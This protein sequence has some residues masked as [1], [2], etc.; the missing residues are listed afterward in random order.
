[1]GRIAV[2][3][4]EFLRRPTEAAIRRLRPEMETMMLS[5]NSFAHLPGLYDRCA[6]EVDGFLASGQ[7]TRAAIESQNHALNRPII[8]FQPDT[9]EIYR[10][11]LAYLLEYP[12]QDLGRVILD[13]LLPLEGDHS[14]KR[15]VGETEMT[16]LTDQVGAWL[17]TLNSGE[18]ERIEENTLR[19]LICLWEEGCFDVV[20]CLFSSIAPALE[21]R[22]IPVRCPC[23][24]DGHL[25]DLLRQL[26]LRVQLTELR[27]SQPAAASAAPRG[28][29]AATP[30]NRRALR[31]YLEEFLQE[32]VLDGMLRE[33]ADGVSIFTTVQEVHLLTGGGR[34]DG[35]GASLAQCLDFPTAVGYGVGGSLHLAVRNARAARRESELTGQ[36][37]LRNE[38]GD[39]IGPLD[40]AGP[41]VVKILGGRDVSEIARRCGLS[42]HTI[43]KVAAAM[44]LSGSRHITAQDLAGRFGVT[45]RNASRILS[46]LV[47]GGYAAVAYHQAPGSRGRPVKVYELMLEL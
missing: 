7:V 37:Y 39:L 10:T 41:L 9:A 12:G 6:P 24:T 42:T 14:A 28:R 38:K 35:L 25:L 5:Y 34:N 47:T 40:A 36:S 8:T 22:G 27:F 29:E 17:E 26:Q 21:R 11:I 3:T 15:L 30:E 43:Q 44:K 33:E 18:L 46:G 32:N 45:A 20:V 19:R 23:V 4:S 13:F 31:E 16:V 1:M 2:I